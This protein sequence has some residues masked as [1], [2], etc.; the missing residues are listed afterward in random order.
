MWKSFL[1]LLV[2]L[3]FVAC[4]EDTIV[5]QCPDSSCPATDCGGGC[6]QADASCPDVQCNSDRCPDGVCPTDMEMCGEECID[7]DTDRR[8]CGDCQTSCGDG[9]VCVDG[10]CVLSCP[11]VLEKCDPEGAAYCANLATDNANCGSCGNVCPDG[12]VC[13]DNACGTTCADTMELCNLDGVAAYCANLATDN[14]NCGS[15]GNV[16]GAGEA[17]GPTGCKLTCLNGLIECA[18]GCV[19]TDYDPENCGSCGNVCPMAI[20]SISFCTPLGCGSICVAGHGDCDGL[21][22]CESDP[23]NDN[24]NCGGCGVEC[25]GGQCMFGQCIPTGSVVQIGCDAVDCP[26]GASDVLA[27]VADHGTYPVYRLIKVTG[28]TSCNNGTLGSYVTEPMSSVE[29]CLEYR[30]QW[31]PYVQCASMNCSG[32]PCSWDETALTDDI[33]GVVHSWDTQCVWTCSSLQCTFQASADGFDVW[34]K[35]G[36]GHVFGGLETCDDGNQVNGD[37]CDEWCQIE[38]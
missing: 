36:D 38:P 33:S 3:A 23:Q 34:Y 24:A 4:G 31:V 11:A 25:T 10:D 17:C 8:H 16:C 1:V 15:C 35:C 13:S 12:Q 18:D 27:A 5:T 22:G 14:A 30:D 9:E 29:S 2:G 26:D 6:Q 32:Y 21:P 37:G 19:D 28:S 20:D 7:T